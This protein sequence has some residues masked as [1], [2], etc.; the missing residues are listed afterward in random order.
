MGKVRVLFSALAICVSFSLG[1]MVV[2][3]LAFFLREWKS[4]VLAVSL[5]NLLYLPL[6]W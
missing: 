1:Y 6:W 4:L 2:P 5:L 3:L